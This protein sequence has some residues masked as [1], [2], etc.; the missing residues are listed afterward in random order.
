[1]TT[2]EYEINAIGELSA[3]DRAEILEHDFGPYWF[4]GVPLEEIAQGTLVAPAVLA[5][6]F[7]EHAK[8]GL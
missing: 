3:A 8:G 4:G 1:M 2:P 6:L 7:R 5:E